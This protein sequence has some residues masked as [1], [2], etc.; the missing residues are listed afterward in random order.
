[1]CGAHQDMKEKHEKEAALK[2]ERD[3]LA[4]DAADKEAANLVKCLD[5]NDQI[6]SA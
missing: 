6:S 1:M 5:A 2:V 3:V 4:K